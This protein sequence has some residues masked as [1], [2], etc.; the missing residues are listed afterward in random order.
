MKYTLDKRQYF[1]IAFG[2]LFGSVKTFLHAL[3]GQK[4]LFRIVLIMSPMKPAHGAIF[5]LAVQESAQYHCMR[6]IQGNR[7]GFQLCCL[8]DRDSGGQQ[9]GK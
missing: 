5:C 3:L 6:Q 1:G 7:L 2:V 8:R 4:H 9:M